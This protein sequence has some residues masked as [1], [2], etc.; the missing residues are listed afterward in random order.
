MTQFKPWLEAKMKAIEDELRVL[1]VPERDTF[2][3][4]S[5]RYQWDKYRAAYCIHLECEEELNAQSS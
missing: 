4:N 2:R 1:P 3:A 5:L